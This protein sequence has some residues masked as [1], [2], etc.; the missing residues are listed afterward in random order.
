MESSSRQ[1]SFVPSDVSPALLTLRAGKVLRTAAGEEIR[2][3]RRLDV[4]L[5]RANGER[6]GLLARLRDLI[7]GHVAIGIT[8]RDP[9]G[10]RLEPGR[11]SAEALGLADRARRPS[12][13]R[14]GQVSGQTR[15]G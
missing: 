12:Q 11:L 4:D 9:D 2:P 3:V 13:P 10:A 15:T 1:S 5:L 7:P 6:I 8:G 14:R